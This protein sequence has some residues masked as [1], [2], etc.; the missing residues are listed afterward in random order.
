MEGFVLSDRDLFLSFQ[1]MR[2]QPPRPLG[3]EVE[4]AQS[5][6]RVTSSM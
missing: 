2:L 3:S 6:T 5:Q 1:D 4:M